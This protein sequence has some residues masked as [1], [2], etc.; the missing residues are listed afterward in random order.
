MDLCMTIKSVSFLIQTSVG[1]AGNSFILLSYVAIL[2]GDCKLM[3]VDIVL[4]HLAF[5]NLMILSTRGIPQTMTVFGM[6]LALDDTSCKI[7][8]YSYRIVRALSVCVTC[9]LSVV[10]AIIITPGTRWSII[11][12]KV[13]K[14]LILSLISI[15]LINIVVCIAAPLFSLVPSGEKP[16][17]FTL[18]LGF[19][20]V[21]FPDQLGYIINGFA[22]SFRD[23][24]FVAL[25]VFASVYIIITLYRH[26]NQVQNIR[27][28]AGARNAPNESKAAKDVLKLVLLY[29][30][31]F[32]IDNIIWIYTLT[33]SHVPSIINDMRIFFTSCYASIS[34]ILII[35][36]NRKIRNA[37][38]CTL[39]TQRPAQTEVYVYHIN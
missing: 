28:M 27:R 19:C 7:I 17:K 16:L 32:G 3:P 11:K 14:Y 29:V 37:I 13:T 20:H 25:M 33:V 8:V 12:I 30:I 10:Q 6:H 36:S 1:I 24:A 18:D 5:V 4:S 22:V 31:F 23:F 38:K 21:R 9:L 35:S 2:F 39:K 34:P 26:R 15:W